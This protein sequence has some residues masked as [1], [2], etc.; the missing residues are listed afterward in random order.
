M[1]E[2]AGAVSFVIPAPRFFS[3]TSRSAENT[4]L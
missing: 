4:V 3:S 2:P 1:S